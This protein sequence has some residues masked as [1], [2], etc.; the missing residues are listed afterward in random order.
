MAK[1]KEASGTIEVQAVKTS[2][3]DLAIVGT[4]PLIVNSMSA[5]AMRSL[6]GPEATGRKTRAERAQN[7]KHDPMQ[8]FLNSMYRHE[9]DSNLTR[10]YFPAPGFKGAMTTA[11]LDLP[12]VK[13]TEIG[14]LSWVKGYGCNV[15]GV[16]QMLMSVVR[17]A[18]IGKTPDVR[19]RAILPEWACA[20]RVHF[21][22]PKLSAAAVVNLMSAA[23][24]TVGIGDFRQERAKGSHGQFRVVEP[25]DPEFQRI[26][27]EGGRVAQDAAIAD[28]EFHDLVTR[29]LFE[30]HR[31]VVMG[32]AA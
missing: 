20:I 3:I 25:N 30:W 24:L 12:G 23:G 19:T 26:L 31:E 27:A 17:M 28:P 14:R 13:K 29:E 21:V 2:Y 8:E 18:D 1:A 11:A 9:G 7:F 5:K 22:Q 4:S 6:L 32:Q 16:P 10:L 15:F